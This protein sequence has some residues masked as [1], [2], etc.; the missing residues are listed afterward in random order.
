[1]KK[2]ISKR[3]KIVLLITFTLSLALFLGPL[4]HP[5]PAA[6]KKVVRDSGGAEVVGALRTTL[7]LGPAMVN[8]FQDPD[9]KTLIV[10]FLKISFTMAEENFEF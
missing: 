3:L 7:L 6:E 8:K 5:R 1:M 10:T 9:N 2:L 4:I